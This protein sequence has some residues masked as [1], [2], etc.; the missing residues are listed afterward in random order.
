MHDPR[1]NKFVH[2]SPE[3]AAKFADPLAQLS[4]IQKTQRN[5]TRFSEGETVE[6]KGMMF[7]V[8]EIGDSR[9]VLKPIAK[10][11]WKG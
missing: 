1:E 3:L 9:L 10:A 4:P 5:W 11:D 2:I 8:H 6:V 7:H